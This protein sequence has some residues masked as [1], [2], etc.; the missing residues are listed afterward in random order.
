MAKTQTLY[1]LLE[2]SPQASLDAI[3]A[4][5]ERLKNKYLEGKLNS[6]Q[7]DATTQFNLIKDAYLTLSRQETRDRYDAKLTANRT[8][9]PT[10]VYA[11]ADYSQPSNIWKWVLVVILAGGAAFYFSAQHKIETE[12]LRLVAE[13][14]RLQLEQAAQLE[15]DQ[16]AQSELQR[17]RA[18]MA[19]EKRQ[20]Y[21][22]ARQRSEL[23]RDSDR[24]NRDL[25]NAAR[26]SQREDERA[27]QQEE[28]RQRQVESQRRQE[29]SE[30]QR[31]IDRERSLARQLEQENRSGSSKAGGIPMRH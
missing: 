2:V 21:E 6:G 24:I 10:V 5:Y 9:G 29:A 30:A 3:H 12:K 14:Q 1:D 16:E 15:K 26:Q 20:E 19:E 11:D 13:A 22:A 4:A 27:R 28:Y 7:L 25:A 17:A 18:A 23:S 8:S 31:R